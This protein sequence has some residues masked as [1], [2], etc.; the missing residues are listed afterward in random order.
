MAWGVR[1]L[2]YVWRVDMETNVPGSMDSQFCQGL[3]HI[4]HDAAQE[5]CREKQASYLL[6]CGA[7]R[8]ENCETLA[9]TSEMLA[10]FR[11]NVNQ[12]AVRTVESSH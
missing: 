6:T 10:C 11:A 9:S 8:C 2:D 1:V 3:S 4:G 7:S 12:S 5:A